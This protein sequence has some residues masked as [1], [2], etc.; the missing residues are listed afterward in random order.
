MSR[1]FYD[2]H[3][4]ADVALNS[5]ALFTCKLLSDAPGCA[6]VDCSDM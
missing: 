2:Y 5:E 3:L 6:P 1:L 4:R